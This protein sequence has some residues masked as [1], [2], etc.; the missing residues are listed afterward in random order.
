VDFG[1]AAYEGLRAEAHGV[2]TLD[3]LRVSLAG[4][5]EV[6]ELVNSLRNNTTLPS[7]R[8]PGAGG[9][10]GI[11]VRIRDP[12]AAPDVPGPVRLGDPG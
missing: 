11:R 8:P 5:D 12:A 9:G 7:A 3:M 1:A 2:G 4:D 10:L 6:R